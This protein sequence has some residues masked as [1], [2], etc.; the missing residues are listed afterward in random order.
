[1]WTERLAYESVEVSRVL[2]YTRYYSASEDPC[3]GAFDLQRY[4]RCRRIGG[5]LMGEA[6]YQILR[7][8]CIIRI[9]AEIEINLMCF[10]V[11]ES[12]MISS[13]M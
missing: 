5:Y 11:E 2:L 4:R 3:V 13:S 10:R 8:C 12:W 7:Y 1:M 6:I 9:G